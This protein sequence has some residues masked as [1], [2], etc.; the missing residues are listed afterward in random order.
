MILNYVPLLAGGRYDQIVEMVLMI[1][2]YDFFVKTMVQE[3]NTAFRKN[4]ASGNNTSNLPLLVDA[5]H[6]SDI[7]PVSTAPEP[8]PDAAAEE[9]EEAAGGLE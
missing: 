2:T 6:L 4:G 9:E 3:A 7:M 5:R 8:E 1:D